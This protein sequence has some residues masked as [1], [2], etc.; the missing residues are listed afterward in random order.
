MRIRVLPRMQE[1]WEPAY[2]LCNQDIG[3]VQIAHTAWHSLR[4]ID[5][6]ER[7]SRSIPIAK[8]TNTSSPIHLARVVSVT[9]QRAIG[10][11]VKREIFNL[12]TRTKM[13]SLFTGGKMK[14]SLPLRRSLSFDR[15]FL[16]ELNFPPIYQLRYTYF[17]I[18][19]Q[20]TKISIATSIS[21]KI[22]SLE[23]HLPR[24]FS[25][26]SSIGEKKNLPLRCISCFSL[27]QRTIRID[28]GD[29]YTQ[30]PWKR[31]KKGRIE[32]GE[33]KGGTCT[34][35]LQ[36]AFNETLESTVIVLQGRGQMQFDPGKGSGCKASYAQKYDP[37]VSIK[38][39]FRLR[40]RS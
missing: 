33:G 9:E 11:G 39:K 37:A 21:R 27:R 16:R 22:F 28:P 1:V 32:R 15:S 31:E 40:L 30:S 10:G 19:G 23:Q 8:I 20:T 4:P 6:I 14:L 5:I 25:S 35:L 17:D 36:R 7:R 13:K 38:S 12:S 29:I 34:L 3:R 24:T 18:F 26:R 2:V